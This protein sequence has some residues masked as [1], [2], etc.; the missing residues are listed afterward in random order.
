MPRRHTIVG[1]GEILWDMLPGGRQ[2]GGAPANF[3]YHANALGADGVVVS[4]VGQDGPG[5]D[6]LSRLDELGLDRRHVTTDPDHPTG[7][8]DVRIDAHGVPDYVIHQDVAWDFLPG[9]QD[10]LALA[11]LAARCD[12]VCF[13]SL[14]QRGP[15]SRR[16]VAAFL[17]ATRPQ[18]L[19]VFD[20]NL[21]QSYFG[22]GTIDTS[23]R[24]SEVLKLNDTE[25]PVL[26][27]L[28]NVGGESP[29][30]MVTAIIRAYPRLRLVALTLGGQGA[31]L[32]TADGQAAHHP[33]FPAE[34]IDT[35]GAGDAF[36][37]ALVP[38]LLDGH[39]PDRINAFANR[40]AAYVCSQPGATPPVPAELSAAR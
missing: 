32:Y 12:A 33:G 19:R 26:S 18:C 31:T 25:L 7:R 10:D 40:L 14:A 8:V 20:V 36:T 17:D 38:G 9:P 39:A 3:A 4:R 34:V 2:L 13:G 27:R 1:L 11:G 21:R 28:L 6:I 23:L 30:A 24:R 5:R 16:A 35:V 29:A 37:A 15:A 22:H